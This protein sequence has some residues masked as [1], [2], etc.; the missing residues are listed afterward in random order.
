MVITGLQ[1]ITESRYHTN[2]VIPVGDQ[3][4]DYIAGYY[5][6]STNITFDSTVEQQIK[7]FDTVHCSTTVTVLYLLFPKNFKVIVEIIL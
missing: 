2:S 5:V 6:D 4:S 1:N 7:Y 3:F